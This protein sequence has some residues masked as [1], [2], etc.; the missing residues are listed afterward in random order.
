MIKKRRKDKKLIRELSDSE[1]SPSSN[2]SDLRNLKEWFSLIDAVTLSQKRALPPVKKLKNSLIAKSKLHITLYGFIVFEVAWRDVRGINYTNELQVASVK[3][4]IL[5]AEIFTSTH[6]LNVYFYVF[7]VKT[8]TSLAIE[9][10]VM[11]RWEFDSIAQAAKSISS[12]FPGT[13][14]EQILLKEHLDATIG[15]HEFAPFNMRS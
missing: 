9:A 14:N 3:L 8:D 13:P 2:T 10:K 6:D 12:W 4:F 7:H 15:I 11:R 5:G 1:T